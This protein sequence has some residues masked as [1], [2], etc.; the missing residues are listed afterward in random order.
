MCQFLYDGKCNLNNISCLYAVTETE[1]CCDNFEE[2]QFDPDE[3]G[4]ERV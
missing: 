1:M 4:H 3:P 2:R